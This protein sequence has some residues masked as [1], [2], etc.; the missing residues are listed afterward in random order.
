MERVHRRAKRIM[1]IIIICLIAIN[2]IGCTGET[3]DG[4]QL[5]VNAESVD[6]Y[7]KLIEDMQLLVNKIYLPRSQYDIDEGKQIIIRHSTSELWDE[8]SK[9][10]GE[11][12]PEVKANISDLSV[13]YI[14]K[15]NTD[16]N[17]HDKV[18]VTF[19]LINQDRSQMHALEFWIDDQGKFNRYNLYQGIIEGGVK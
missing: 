9:E 8:L 11:Y 6:G 19:R 10:I 3:K 1:T 12:N 4:K 16:T 15:E 5:K 17:L 13:S 14:S 18:N 7:F 2:L